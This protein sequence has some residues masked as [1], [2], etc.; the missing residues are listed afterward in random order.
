MTASNRGSSSR[1]QPGL[2][3]AG[4]IEILYHNQEEAGDGSSD[5]ESSCLPERAPQA[6]A[7][8]KVAF[9]SHRSQLHGG[10]IAS[11]TASCFGPKIL[12]KSIKITTR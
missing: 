5:P 4:D 7:L 6:V 8:C 12:D 10:I 11:L 1:W 3:K 9:Y 2:S